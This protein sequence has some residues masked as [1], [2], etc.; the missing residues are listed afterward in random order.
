MDQIV[1]LSAEVVFQEIGGE[2]VLLDLRT[3]TYFGLDPVGTRIWQLLAADGQVGRVVEQMLAEYDVARPRLE[4]DVAALLA[5][6][7]EAGLVSVA[8][9][10]SDSDAAAAADLDDA[11]GG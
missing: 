1:T 11:A 3:S 10:A 6:L 5:E 4:A 9:G 8:H 2:S 7:A